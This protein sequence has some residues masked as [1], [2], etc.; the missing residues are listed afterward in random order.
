VS[1]GSSESVTEWLEGLKQ[2][3]SDAAQ[4]IWERYF[5]RLLRLARARLG[6]TRSPQVDHDDVVSEAFA[7]FCRAVEAGRF[8]KLAD[9]DDLWQLLVMLTER[10]VVDQI[11]RDRAKKR[12]MPAAAA[13][14]APTLDSSA[15]QVGRATANQIVDDQPTPA[16]A[17]ELAEQLQLLLSALPND[18]MRNIVTAKLEGFTNQE[19]SQRLNTSLRNVER[20]LG[21]IRRIWIERNTE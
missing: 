9:R 16:L 2:G 18:M 21:L 8:P 6:P 12:E 7:N 4:R 1:Q 5:D 10:R 14:A 20:K 11:R 19:I 13:T 3:E 17:A 15:G